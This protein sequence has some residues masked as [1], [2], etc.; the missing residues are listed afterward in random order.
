MSKMDDLSRR[1]GALQ[2][3]IERRFGQIRVWL[4]A[5]SLVILLTAGTD[6]PVFALLA[7]AVMR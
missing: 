3:D 4:V 6:S 1:L 5:V 2:L 7:A